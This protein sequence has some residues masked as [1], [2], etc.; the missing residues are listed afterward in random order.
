M[1]EEVEVEE[2]EVEEEVEEVEDPA[3]EEVEEMEPEVSRASCSPACLACCSHG[4]SVA[5]YITYNP[6]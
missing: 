1:S 2:E 4:E 6:T 3:S 5:Y